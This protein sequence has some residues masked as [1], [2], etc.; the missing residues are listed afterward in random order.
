MNQVG[1]EV[2]RWSTDE[3]EASQRVDY[4]SAALESSVDPARVTCVGEPPFSAQ[5]TAAP[6]GPVTAVRVIAESHSLRRGPSELARSGDPHFRLV[7]VLSCSWRL[8][9]HGAEVMRP[10]DVVLID[11][12]YPHDTEIPGSFEA[13]HLKLSEQW[14]QQWVPKAG[15][16]A[17]Q[18]I[19]F[20]QNW[21]NALSSFVAQ[22]SPE[23]A[24]QAPLPP[25]LVADHLGV[26]L[27]LASGHFSQG[28]ALVPERTLAMRIQECTIQ[29]C[30]ELFLTAADVAASLGISVRTL[31]RSLASCR[32]SFA[33]L[34][35][36]A[37]VTQAMRL[38]EAP[39]FAA[40]NVAEIG[41]RCGFADASHFT[42]VM[43]RRTGRSPL[44]I[45]RR[46]S[47]T[48][49]VNVSFS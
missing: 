42:R 45:Q 28:S 16:M 18:P 43:R 7:V 46:E 8:Q 49:G 27:S 22:M 40:L 9:H 48:P 41:R 31:H 1:T 19:R 6:L 33:A 34:L 26:L 39:M 25:H 24:I 12:R 32:Q 47:P 5:I 10:R 2:V 15:Q 36:D 20:D 14:V 30:P 23:F 11:S 13:I 29:R 37:R 17:G 4:Y 38:L 35:I 21:G 44:Q 3:V